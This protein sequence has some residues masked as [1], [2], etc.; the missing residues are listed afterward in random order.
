MKLKSK[1][2]QVSDK[3]TLRVHIPKMISLLLNINN[4]DILVWDYDKYSDILTLN[5][6]KKSVNE[7]KK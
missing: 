7:L 2:G 6:E 5:L 4:G 3:G 1:V